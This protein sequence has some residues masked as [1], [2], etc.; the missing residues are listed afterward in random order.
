EEYPQELKQSVVSYAINVGFQA[1]IESDAHMI[2]LEDVREA[3]NDNDIEN[4][5]C[6]DVEEKDIVAQVVIDSPKK[7]VSV[8]VGVKHYQIT[9]V[10][11]YFERNKQDMLWDTFE[12]QDLC[13][14]L[15]VKKDNEDGQKDL[16]LVGDTESIEE[17]EKMNIKMLFKHKRMGKSSSVMIFAEIFGW[18]PGLEFCL[19]GNFS[20]LIVAPLLVT[21]MKEDL[22]VSIIEH[23]NFVE[24]VVIN[25]TK[26]WKFATNLIIA[27]SFEWIPGWLSWLIKHW[28]RIIHDSDTYGTGGMTKR[29]TVKGVKNE[30]CRA[31]FLYNLGS[32]EPN[33][34]MD[35][36]S[37]FSS[38]KWAN[39]ELISS[40]LKGTLL[41]DKRIPY[42]VVRCNK[43]MIHGN[44]ASV[45]DE[46]LTF[47][48]FETSLPCVGVPSI[49][50]ATGIVYYI[51]RGK[52]IMLK[53]VKRESKVVRW[54]VKWKWKLKKLYRRTMSLWK[55]DIGSLDPWGQGS[56]EEEGIVMCLTQNRLTTELVLGLNLFWIVSPVSR[57]IYLNQFSKQDGITPSDNGVRTGTGK[58]WCFTY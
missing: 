29:G 40:R 4:L 44:E 14:T 28:W 58:F 17:M 39:E 52:Y 21:I 12:I 31:I 47:F 22:L 51:T 41:T 6:E 16:S 53:E 1:I 30:A 50:F 25:D 46:S 26:T 36:S 37:Q 57:H 55:K 3:K 18:K 56:F 20:R 2:Q 54:L 32:V 23:G 24:V 34:A 42:L 49:H 13:P 35:L 45:A 33:V 19:V 8:L 15:E 9:K 43:A 7:S 11:G 27:E 10:I 48:I 5:V 38:S